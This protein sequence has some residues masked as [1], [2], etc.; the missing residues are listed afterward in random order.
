M[1]IELKTYDALVVG[2]DERSAELFGMKELILLTLD[3]FLLCR[4]GIPLVVVFTSE[5]RVLQVVS[6]TLNMAV[7]Q[8]GR[9]F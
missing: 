7:R 9:K 1:I 2:D 3:F 6:V 4:I 5:V 8:L